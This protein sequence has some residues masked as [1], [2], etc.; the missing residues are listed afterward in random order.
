MTAIVDG[1]NWESVEGAAMY[2]DRL[3]RIRALAA[4]GSKISFGIHSLSPAIYAT[5]H[6]PQSI[7][8]DNRATFFPANWSADNAYYTSN[9]LAEGIEAGGT[10]TIT[11]YNDKEK[12]VSG[13]FKLLLTRWRS[14]KDGLIL[15]PAQVEEVTL[16]GAFTDISVVEIPDN[17]AFAKID[18]IPVNYEAKELGGGAGPLYVGVGMFRNYSTISIMLP[19]NVLPGTYTLDGI[20]KGMRIF[21]GVYEEID[22]TSSSFRYP[23]AEGTIAIIKHNRLTDR[24]E[25]TFSFNAVTYPEGETKYEIRE[26]TFAITYAG[27]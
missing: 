1:K 5:E 14:D 23:A 12:L 4:D 24:L 19:D 16:E 25:G 18:G 8:I 21:K 15:S 6:D 3:Y 26:G 10:I 2:K 27:L 7:F 20:E 22:S 11:D 9:R 17:T 13:T